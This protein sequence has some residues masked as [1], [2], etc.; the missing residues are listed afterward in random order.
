MNLKEQFLKKKQKQFFQV[1]IHYEQLFRQFSASQFLQILSCN[2][3][4]AEKSPTH[5]PKKDFFVESCILW[6]LNISGNQVPTL[7]PP[8]HT[9]LSLSPHYYIKIYTHKLTHT[10]TLTLTLTHSLTQN[11]SIKLTHNN[12]HS[13][14]LT[15]SHSHTQS[16]SLTITLL[17]L[18]FTHSLIHTQWLTHS[19]TNT[20]SLTHTNIITVTL[21]IKLKLTYSIAHYLIYS[22]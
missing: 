10:N 16:H 14:S 2:I 12:I 13:H 7:I 19:N 21:T 3:F 5:N 4:P 9:H 15:P 18:T 1:F 6:A 11:H 8:L 22:Y 17:K 20:H